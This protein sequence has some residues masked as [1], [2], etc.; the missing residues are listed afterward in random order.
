MIQNGAKPPGVLRTLLDVVS[1]V[2]T[3]SN[4]ESNCKSIVSDDDLSLA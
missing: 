2:K 4:A 3:T 1:H